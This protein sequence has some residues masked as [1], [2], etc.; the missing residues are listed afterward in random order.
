MQLSLCMIVKNEAELLP[1]CLS[2]VQGLADEVILVDTGSTDATIEIGQQ[3]GVQVYSYPW[4]SDFAAARN[5]SLSYAKGDWVL[6]LDADEV[7]VPDVI[8]VLRQAMQQDDYL[9]INLLRHEL[10]SHQSPYSLVSRL[11]RNRTDIFF[12]RPYHE[13]VDDS[14]QVI[15]N[16][17]PHWRVGC[18]QDVALLHK[19]YEPERIN[20]KD[21]FNRAKD[22]LEQALIDNPDDA[23]LYSKFGALC[24]EMGNRE[25][26][27]GLLHRGLELVSVADS[28]VQYELHFH[29]GTFYSELNQFDSALFHYQMAWKQP[30][31]PRLRL[32]S[33][34]NWANLLQGKGDLPEACMLYEKVVAIA[35]DFAV[36]YFNLGA[37]L[38]AMGLLPESIVQYRKAIAL[39]PEYAEAY[40]NLG[41]VLF[42]QG[43]VRD[44][45][46]AFKQAISLYETQRSPEG[47]LLRE[48]L[49]V[50]GFSWDGV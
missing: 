21:K 26:G 4:R 42:K 33:L 19:G 45:F 13:L 44:S 22:I 8:P 31:P 34:N 30:I 50:F 2:S 29:L 25:R 35:P 10:G 20:R 43:K 1:D 6:V 23:Y 39:Q 36:G 49:G 7:V 46:L 17:E 14:I 32:G 28:A 37:A 18:I 40:Q 24:W 16:R 12:H 27:L 5:H 48:K 41:V 47:Q 15:L 38:K 11:F 3:W 9:L